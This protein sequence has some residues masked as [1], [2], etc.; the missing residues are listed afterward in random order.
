[1]GGRPGPWDLAAEPKR[2]HAPARR[3]GVIDFTQGPIAANLARLAW[4]LVVGNILQ[5]VYNLVDMFWVGR[6]GAAAVAAVSIVFPTDWL[7]TSIAMGITV[8]G[9]A[10]V[11]QW[12]GAGHPR[13][14]N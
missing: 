4:P 13:Q 1:M 12:T 5:T 10:L 2:S 14:A 6:L 7:L 9:A 8:A 11:A 3:Q